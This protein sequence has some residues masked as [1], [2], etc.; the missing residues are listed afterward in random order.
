MLG[1]QMH[2]ELSP[3]AD[4]LAPAM[5]FFCMLVPWGRTNKDIC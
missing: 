2:K 3:H 5:A 4:G 1:K